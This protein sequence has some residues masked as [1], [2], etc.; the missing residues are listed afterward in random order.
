MCEACNVHDD[1]VDW[2]LLEMTEDAKVTNTP[3]SSA[4]SM[5]SG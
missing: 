5:P 2:Q 1:D 3:D 4:Q